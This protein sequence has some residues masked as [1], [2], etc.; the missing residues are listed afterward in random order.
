MPKYKKAPKYLGND[1]TVNLGR[2]DLKLKDNVEYGNPKLAR[3]VSLGFVVEVKG[4]AVSVPV[5]APA[6]VPVV[7][8][9]SKPVEKK[10]TP[11]YTELELAK[12][13]KAAL[14][15]LAASMEL[16]LEMSL[17]KAEMIEEI[18]AKQG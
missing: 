4:K 2:S 7:P 16:E 13:N 8:S 10:K 15:D 11:R 5:A 1:L 9:P 17:T 12:N 6:P 3:F 14:V 18:L